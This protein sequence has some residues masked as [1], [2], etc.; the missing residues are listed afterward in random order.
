[1]KFDAWHGPMMEAIIKTVQCSD[2]S[3]YFEFQISLSI[4]KMFLCQF[5]LFFVNQS[6]DNYV[7]AAMLQ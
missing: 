7:D 2:I 4:I 1:M 3:N 5:G 6:H